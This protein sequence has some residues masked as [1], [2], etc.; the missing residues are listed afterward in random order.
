MSPCV[1]Q[2]AP[3]DPRRAAVVGEM[4]GQSMIPWG[5]CWRGD[6]AAAADPRGGFSSE[7]EFLA[8]Y[9]RAVAELRQLRESR[10]YTAAVITQTTDVEEELNG[11]FSYDRKVAKVN[12]AAL[13]DIH[14]TLVQ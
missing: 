12:L 2:Y 8:A 7:Q 1:P 4:W 5:H 10:G 6:A 3:A 14:K 9:R 11:F 13:A